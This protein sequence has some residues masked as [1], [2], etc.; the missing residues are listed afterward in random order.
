MAQFKVVFDC[1]NDTFHPRFALPHA[2][3]AALKDIAKSIDARGL[4]VGGIIYDENG[5]SIG[6]WDYSERNDPSS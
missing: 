2:I 3:K 5:N 6:H 1:D 4:D